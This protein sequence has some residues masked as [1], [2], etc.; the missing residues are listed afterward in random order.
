[1]RLPDGSSPYSTIGPI[2]IVE[3][4]PGGHLYN[5]VVAITSL[6]SRS[7][8]TLETAFAV[9]S[10]G[11]ACLIYHDKAEK[12]I[13]TMSGDMTLT[14]RT[15]VDIG[16]L[17]DKPMAHTL[18]TI[19]EIKAADAPEYPSD[20]AVY[21]RPT[22]TGRKTVAR[23]VVAYRDA[24]RWSS[25]GPSI[26]WFMVRRD[27]QGIGLAQ[28]LFDEVEK[29]YVRNWAL[30]TNKG[31]RVLKA[32]QLKDYIVDRS[33]EMEGRPSALITD[34]MFFYDVSRVM[35][36]VLLATSQC[37]VTKLARRLY[38]TF[39]SSSSTAGFKSRNEGALCGGSPTWCAATIFP[40]TILSH[41]LDRPNYFDFNLG[42]QH[43]FEIYHKT[44][45]CIS[46]NVFVCLSD[47][48]LISPGP[49]TPPPPKP[50]RETRY[51][52]IQGGHY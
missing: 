52:I 42:I 17:E 1:M 11:S 18:T 43:T 48:H 8:S 33:D 6:S 9:N 12:P 44:P 27:Y 45:L 28:Q 23:C 26:R 41:C 49:P 15:G 24:S 20:R 39:H 47:Q 5:E 16:L 34:K 46:E 51:Y 14:R 37:L 3:D 35:R 25:V 4:F 40:P 36:Y 21:E 7:R 31:N 13:A 29:W 32:T 50:R 30:N 22:G 10:P 2:A 19:F 38:S